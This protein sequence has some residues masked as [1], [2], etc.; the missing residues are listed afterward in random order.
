MFIL[1]PSDRVIID[2]SVRIPFFLQKTNK[3]KKKKKKRKK[4]KIGQIL[5]VGL[6]LY[7]VP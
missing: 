3:K 4:E 1:S 6:D 2:S 7:W 5:I